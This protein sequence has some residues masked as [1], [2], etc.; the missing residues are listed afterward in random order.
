TEVRTLQSLAVRRELLIPL[1]TA[2][3]TRPGTDARELA[4]TARKIATT[5]I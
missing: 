1:A 3:E 2:L 5:P 4:R